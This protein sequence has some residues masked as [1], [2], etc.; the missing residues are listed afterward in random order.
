MSTWEWTHQIKSFVTSLACCSTPYLQFKRFNQQFLVNWTDL[1]KWKKDFIFELFENPILFQEVSSVRCDESFYFTR[2]SVHF[3]LAQ[4][5]ASI[6]VIV[7]RWFFSGRDNDNIQFVMQLL[8]QLC[9]ITSAI[10]QKLSIFHRFPL[11]LSN[12]FHSLE[13]LR[14]FSHENTT[15]LVKQRLDPSS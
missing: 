15:R 9:R 5:W 10:E 8:R 14:R 2:S 3:K 12:I 7:H 6:M 13:K 11:P 4:F 1:S